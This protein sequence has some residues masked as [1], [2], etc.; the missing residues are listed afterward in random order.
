MYPASEAPR[1]AR[2]VRF[3]GLHE[4]TAADI[5]ARFPLIEE[6]VFDGPKGPVPIVEGCS[7]VLVM[8]YWDKQRP[9][10][11]Q[12]VSGELRI[13]G[14][15]TDSIRL[16]HIRAP[17]VRIRR[18]VI[19]FTFSIPWREIIGVV[20]GL[21]ELEI[22]GAWDVES[23]ADMLAAAARAGIR[24]LVVWD[25]IHDDDGP[26]DLSM[27]PEYMIV[28]RVGRW[29]G[30]HWTA[31]RGSVRG[32]RP[33]W[34]MLGDPRLVP[35]VLHEIT[36]AA[37]SRAPLIVPAIPDPRI[38]D[39]LRELR[40][41]ELTLLAHH[42]SDLSP[43]IHALGPGVESLTLDIAVFSHQSVPHDELAALF[44]KRVVR[45]FRAV[46]G[47]QY[48]W[49]HAHVLHEKSLA[50]VRAALGLSRLPLV[51]DCIRMVAEKIPLD[52]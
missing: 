23:A 49:K 37:D 16:Y 9:I 47:R 10:I 46:Y 50:R 14:L 19:D 25:L 39:A 11:T 24:R 13:V 22:C 30:N 45:K 1:H 43:F 20:P 21:E 32:L 44:R 6:T 51:R 15:G 29:R 5:K 36:L 31:V 12:D 40:S 38:L 3:S 34:G 33:D 18:L 26:P 28:G 17:G 7:V 2:S 27:I 52:L 8:R 35:D 4:V 48:Y 42:P 41:G